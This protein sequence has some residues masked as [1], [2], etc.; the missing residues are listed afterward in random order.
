M[1]TT[2]T[3]CEACYQTPERTALPTL[4]ARILAR[5]LG[6]IVAERRL[7]RDAREL[8][9]LSDHMLK[10]IGLSRSQV[11]HTVRFGRID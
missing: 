3:T 7:R 5:F 11:G 6:A 8:M 2:S 4:F 1:T 9:T 10:D